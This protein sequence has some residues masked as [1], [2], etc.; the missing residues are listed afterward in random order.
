MPEETTAPFAG[1]S[2]PNYTQTPNEFYEQL[3]P[4]IDSLPELKVA[5]IL[6]RQTFG[7][8]R[9]HTQIIF[10]CSQIAKYT[11]LDKSQALRGLQA[12][13]ERGYIYRREVSAQKF[14]Y[15]LQFVSE[16]TPEN[17]FQTVIPPEKPLHGS[18]G[19]AKP[20]HGS[21]G[22]VAP[23]QRFENPSLYT[24]RKEIHI[25]DASAN[26]TPRRGRHPKGPFPSVVVERGV[27]CPEDFTP[28][29]GARGWA[30]RTLPPATLARLTSLTEQFVRKY[31]EV[32]RTYLPDVAAWEARWKNFMQTCGDNDLARAA[33]GRGRPND[34]PAIE[35]GPSYDQLAAKGLV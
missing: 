24:K 8:H 6:I 28:S 17:D 32:E 26:K 18:N 27:R 7:F 9:Q 14:A 20:L 4:Q 16:E 30:E 29:A 23:G 35:E 3:L 22:T 5:L 21:N 13:M 25:T 31:R 1:F 11:G 2:K 15:G 10:S 33:Q 12:G 19:C 34:G